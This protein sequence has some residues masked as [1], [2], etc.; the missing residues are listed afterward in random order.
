MDGDTV[1]GLAL[2]RVEL[3]VDSLGIVRAPSSRAA[4]LNRLFA[5]AADQFEIACVDAVLTATASRTAP[6]YRDLCPSAFRSVSSTS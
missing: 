4:L 5:A 1:F 2:P 3:P 6:S